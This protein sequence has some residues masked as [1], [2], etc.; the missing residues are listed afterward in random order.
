M[1]LVWPLVLGAPALRSLFPQGLPEGELL[2]QAQPMLLP[3]GF[4][5]PRMAWEQAL[6]MVPE[7]AQRYEQG[8]GPHAVWKD[9]AEEASLRLG[10]ALLALTG[11]AREGTYRFTASIELFNAAL[12]QE[13][14]WALE[15][16]ASQSTG[17]L[18]E[19]LRGLI[20]LAAG[21][22]RLQALDPE[23][24]QCLLGEA[25]LQLGEILETPWGR[26][27]V[28]KSRDAARDRLACLAGMS[29]ADALG[30]LWEGSRPEWELL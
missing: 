18:Q 23:G 19:S 21:F 27:D 22:S 12:F 26:L 6:Q 28:S 20:R 29:D 17:S 4:A 16:L 5:E 7:L 11:T 13:C 2:V 9:V 24:L 3:L 8:W 30:H 10:V 15:P 25:L 1:L 14:C